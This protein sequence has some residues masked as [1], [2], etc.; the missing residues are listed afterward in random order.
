MI[1]VIG[2]L[3]LVTFPL[4]IIMQFVKPGSEKSTAFAVIFSACVFGMMLLASRLTNHSKVN[5][6]FKNFLLAGLSGI[7]GLACAW[8][9]IV[10][11]NGPAPSDSK[12][13]FLFFSVFSLLAAVF[14]AFVSYSHLSGKNAFKTIQVLVFAPVIMYIMSLTLFLSFELGEPSAYNV[15]AQ[16]LSLLFFVYYS[17]FYVKCSEKNFRR[18]CLAFGIPSVF[19]NLCYFLPVVFS[20]SFGSMDNVFS[21]MSL[22]ISIYICLFLLSDFK[23]SSEKFEKI[24][25]SKV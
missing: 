23:L 4:K 16:C 12:F 21:V 20:T 14:F 8:N 13:K 6:S 9:G 25:N 3:G 1:M 2:M 17:H 7:C 15:L 19:V 22:A 18:R 11:F 24:Q 10:H 5:Y